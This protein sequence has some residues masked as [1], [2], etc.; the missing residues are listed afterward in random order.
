M[1]TDKPTSSDPSTSC[2]SS[3]QL[4]ALNFTGG[5]A[6]ELA[7]LADVELIGCSMS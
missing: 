3:S 1:A 7:I 6:T 4:V 5:I 2:S